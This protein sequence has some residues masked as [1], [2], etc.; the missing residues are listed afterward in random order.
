M[1]LLLGA[2]AAPIPGTAKLVHT[3]STH[4][5]QEAVNDRTQYLRS[6]I[7]ALSLIHI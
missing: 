6:S 4:I 1:L 5:W 2:A 3:A 7:A